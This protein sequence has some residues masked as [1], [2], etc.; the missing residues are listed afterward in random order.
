MVVKMTFRLMGVIIVQMKLVVIEV[1]IQI[2]E[3]VVGTY[4]KIE[5]AVVNGYTKI[6]D[7]FVNRYLT[8]DGESV[9]EAKERL[10]R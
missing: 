8:K 2:E 9:E 7:A 4:E 10:K 1:N 5:H 6:E 3:K